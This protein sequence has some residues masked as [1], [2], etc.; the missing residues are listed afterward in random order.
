MV[1]EHERNNLTKSDKRNLRQTSSAWADLNY[2]I[3]WIKVPPKC[4]QPRLKGSR[5]GNRGVHFQVYTQNDMT[6]LSH[7]R[8]VMT[9]VF[10]AIF[11]VILAI[12][13]GSVHQH[14]IDLLS[15]K[16][17]VPAVRGVNTLVPALTPWFRRFMELLSSLYDDPADEY[18]FKPPVSCQCK[19]QVQGNL[20]DRRNSS[21]Y[22]HNQQDRIFNCV[23]FYR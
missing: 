6:E 8:N 14:L 11:C 7:C 17:A 1:C 18:R 12:Y 22:R 10:S 13:H 5:R 21:L 4:T 23:V 19:Q 16:K 3:L 15:F 20:I 9:I 2:R